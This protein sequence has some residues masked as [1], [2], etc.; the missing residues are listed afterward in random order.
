MSYIEVICS[1]TEEHRSETSAD[2]V[3]ALLS[4]FGFESFETSG[5]EVKA[6]I[7]EISFDK[8]L[9]SEWLEEHRMLIDSVDINQIKQE[10]WNLVWES[11][12]PMTVIRDRCVVFA[13][14]H[15]NVPDLEYKINILPQMSFGT[16]H[17]ET[18]SLMIELMLDMDVKGKK[19]LDMGSGTGILAILA[20]MKEAG[21]I[22]A[23]DID[24]WAYKNAIENCERNAITN[25]KIELGDSGILSGNS[26]DLIL[27]NINRNILM[28]DIHIYAGCIQDKGMLQVSGFYT[29]DLPDIIDEAKRNGLKYV[30][31]VT[32]KDWVAAQF[33]K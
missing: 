15:T 10:N 16:G 7:R 24:E 25:I 8:A 23:V 3:V 2:I 19:V 17:H 9:F 21:Q 5:E 29:A 26:F 30:R 32:K 18:T 33:I 22:M 11:N 27:A 4:E 13:P 1:L 20:S 6:Y 14:F 31:H 28:N 12:F